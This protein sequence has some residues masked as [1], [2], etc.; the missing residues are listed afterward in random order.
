MMPAWAWRWIGIVGVMV[1]LG[2]AY[3]WWADRLEQRGYARATAQWQQRE[4]AIRAEVS[5]R[6]ADDLA[7]ALRRTGELQDKVN[8][9]TVTRTAMEE[10]HE[11]ELA[12]ARADVRA[13]AQRLRVP[14]KPAAC[15][16][17]R[18]TPG[19]TATDPARLA[20][21]QTADILPEVAADFVSVAGAAAKDVRDYNALYAYT[22]L[23]LS[24]CKGARHGDAK[25]EADDQ[26]GSGSGAEPVRPV[27]ALPEEPVQ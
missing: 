4:A 3:T 7:T 2:L 26:Q 9:M 10:A 19:G 14:V 1:L 18:E 15:P 21:P 8:T 20:Q 27:H 16:V 25:K 5:A 6:Y 22:E 13:G 11:K 24:E 17:L 12:Q 23:I